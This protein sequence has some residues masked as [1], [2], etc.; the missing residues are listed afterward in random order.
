MCESA[1]G[2]APRRLRLK[3]ALGRSHLAVLC[4]DA[5]SEVERHVYQEEGVGEDV[6]A[7]PRQPTV[8]VQEGDLHGDPNQVEECDGH[9]AHDVVAPAGGGQQ[10]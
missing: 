3:R 5:H 8:A 2:L 9:H 7:L 4:D 6:E 10:C 1:V